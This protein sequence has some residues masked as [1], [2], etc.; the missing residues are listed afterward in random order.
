M[1]SSGH[2]QVPS[3][4]SFIP[5]AGRFKQYFEDEDVGA[6]VPEA[7]LQPAVLGGISTKAG[8]A[9]ASLALTLAG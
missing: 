2:I 7:G 9:G 3:V 1:S 4:S 6:A 8:A 5:T